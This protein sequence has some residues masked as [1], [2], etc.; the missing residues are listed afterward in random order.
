[1]DKK[2]KIYLS[3]FI[4]MFA[5]IVFMEVTKPKPINWYPSYASH[6]K[7]PFGTY[8][9]S[10]ELESL[11]PNTDIKTIKSVPYQYLK[12]TTVKGTYFFLNGG[13][14]FG[15]DEFNEIIKFV[16]RGNDVFMSTDGF[17]IDT[18][19]LETKQLVT[20]SFKEHSYYKLLNVHLDTTQIS[21]DRRS[22]NL[23]FTKVDTLKTTALG[24]LIIKNPDSINGAEGINF[25]KY[26]LGKGN[27]FFH[28]FP[29][30]FTNYGILK[31]NN[32]NYVASTLSYIDSNKPILLDAYYK[33]GK[34]KIT[35]PMYYVLSSD[36]LRW[37]YYTALI[38]VLFFVFFKGKRTQRIIPIITPLKNQTLAF[39]RT[40]A[41]MYFEKASHKS[42]ADHK[43]NYFL[44]YIRTHLNIP[45]TSISEEFFNSVALRSGNDLIDV[46]KIFK[47]IKSIQNAKSIHKDQLIELNVLIEQ[48]KNKQL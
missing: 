15:K 24:K 10:Q 8:I 26:K 13:L 42:I 2:L 33:S 16:N 23:V 27:F 9:L 19:G 28:T 39:T 11:F 32:Y 44:D 46:Q 20:N 40:I 31:D 29:Q 37:A 38:G 5:L 6:H 18:L 21:F 25:I 22:S 7:I 14:N 41:N 47:K 1:M 30:A 35:S 3:I 12:D 48:F 45:T 34:S 36:N 17:S 43:I 4:A